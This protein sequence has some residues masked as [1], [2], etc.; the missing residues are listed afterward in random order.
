MQTVGF[1]FMTTERNNLITTTRSST[2]LAAFVYCSRDVVMLPLPQIFRCVWSQVVKCY[3]TTDRDYMGA[4]TDNTI[5]WT[6]SR[7][8]SRNQPHYC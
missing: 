7:Q 6:D 4:R 5:V 1:G 8:G 3:V 2:F